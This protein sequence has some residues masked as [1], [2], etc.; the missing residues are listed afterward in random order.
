MGHPG[1]G[2]SNNNPLISPKIAYRLFIS[3]AHAFPWKFLFFNSF[4]KKR[5]RWKTCCWPMII[6]IMEPQGWE[7]VE[8]AFWLFIFPL[9]PIL[10]RDSCLTLLSTR[11]SCPGKNC[12]QTPEASFGSGLVVVRATENLNRLPASCGLLLWVPSECIL[13]AISFL[14]Y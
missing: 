6:L 8:S 5:L 9:G 11:K 12:L 3:F 7:N 13:I 2:S 10:S 14:T 4:R 1:N